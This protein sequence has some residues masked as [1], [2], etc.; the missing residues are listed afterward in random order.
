[1]HFFRNYVDVLRAP[2]DRREWL[3]FSVHPDWL[4]EPTLDER[5]HTVAFAGTVKPAEHYPMRRWAIEVLQAHIPP[6]RLNGLRY[7]QFWRSTLIGLTCT[8][9][10]K[11]DNA[12]HVIIPGAGA[13]LLTDGTVGTERLLGP[14][15]LPYDKNPDSLRANVQWAIDQPEYALQKRK[16]AYDLVATKHTHAARWDDLLRAML[17][18]PL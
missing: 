8:S 11:Y 3:P 15:W 1:M 13:L 4:C 6:K 9:A 18:K 7:M 17:L 2:F 14:N 12:K 5:P 16:A 10:A